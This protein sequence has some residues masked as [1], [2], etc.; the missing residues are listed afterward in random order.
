MR[1]MVLQLEAVCSVAE[2]GN[3]MTGETKFRL[4]LTFLLLG[5]F[6]L[7]MKNL[8]AKDI[9]T[10][11]VKPIVALVNPH[12]PQTFRV[13]FWIEPSEDNRE[14][15]YQATCG[16]ELKSSIRTIHE[17]FYTVF[18]DLYVLSDCTFQVCISRVGMKVPLCVKQKVLTGG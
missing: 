10:L 16:G 5:L 12:K 14:Y 15:A 9:L 3:Q 18:E 6:S 17:V 11:D 8:F 1:R 7:L 2:D 4:A 13:R